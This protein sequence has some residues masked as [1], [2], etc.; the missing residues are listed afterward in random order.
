TDETHPSLPPPAGVHA[1]SPRTKRS[2]SESGWRLTPCAGGDLVGRPGTWRLLPPS[3]GEAVTSLH[4]LHP[5]R[6]SGHTLCEWLNSREETEPYTSGPRLMDWPVP[7]D[8]VPDR[9]SDSLIEAV[10]ASR[11]ALKKAASGL[12][13]NVFSSKETDPGKLREDLRAA[14]SK[15]RLIDTLVVPLEDPMWRAESSYPFHVAALAR[16][17]RTST[18]AAERKDGLLK[19]GEGIARV[20]GVLTLA[21][22]IAQDGF[23]RR[24]QQQFSRGATFGT[25]LWLVNN[26]V[27]DLTSPGVQELTG[28]RE[29]TYPL[30]EKVKD[31]R[32]DAHHA[33]GVRASHEIDGEVAEL[34]PHVVSA[35]TS[36]NWLSRT[37]WDWVER[38]EY[39]D[40]SQYRLAGLRL[41]GSHPGWEPFE[42]FSQ[43]P[44]RPDRIY[45]T[46]TPG[47]A[48]V[49]LWPLAS[50]S[51]CTVCN[52]RELF[53]ID[54]IRDN[55]LTLRSLEEHWMEIPYAAP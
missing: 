21:E 31:L 5:L 34:E 36:V 48:L 55:K 25:W 15:A 6:G 13:P 38:C 32:N 47:A 44:V 45:I 54:E 23:T 35:L 22:K 30:L 28:V 37:H 3:F 41:T 7:A 9:E 43:F 16:R 40:E 2:R 17:Y 12:L 51:L 19:L 46:H 49:G 18:H 10:D 14:A 27:A 52:A 29:K 8:F 39:L 50:V 53:L 42:R 26:L 33:H 20:L 11:Q 24:L 1:H 4:V